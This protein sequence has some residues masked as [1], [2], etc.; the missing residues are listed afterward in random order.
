M[1]M[2]S[3]NLVIPDDKYNDIKEL[4]HTCAEMNNPYIN[5]ETAE[6]FLKMV[7]DEEY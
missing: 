1:V 6:Y 7:E 4:L 5:H 3:L 2:M